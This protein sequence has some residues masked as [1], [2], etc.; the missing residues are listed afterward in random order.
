MEQ[1]L[2]K[3]LDPNDPVVGGCPAI[4]RCIA[5]M[6]WWW[7]GSSSNRASMLWDRDRRSTKR[8]TSGTRD[9]MKAIHLLAKHGGKWRPRD[10]REI[11]SARR[12]FLQLTPDYIVEFVWIMWKYGGC[13]RESVL[14]LLRTPSVR[15]HVSD[16]RVR[17]NELLNDWRE[18]SQSDVSPACS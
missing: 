18:P 4:A 11:Q 16:H 8:D 13:A 2:A 10:K 9:I 3:G 6:D 1:L 5:S 17:L 7:Y 15:A 14:E 12:S